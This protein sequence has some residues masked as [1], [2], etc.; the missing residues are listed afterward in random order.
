MK[1]LP[2]CITLSRI[3]SSLAL[4]FVRTFSPMFFVI[5]TYC[6]VSDVL[7]G[8]LA[9][10]FSLSSENGARLD[11]IADIVCYG[12]TAVKIMPSLLGVLTSPIWWLITVV[13]VIRI[14]SYTVAMIKYHCFASLH[15][16]MNKL[17]GFLIFTIPYIIAQPFAL[18][19]SIIITLVALLAASEEL[20]IHISANQYSSNRKTLFVNR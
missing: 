9:R 19:A 13:L 12:I 2:N 17:T 4:L 10:K 14:I 7:D 8:F 11:S 16:Y 5:Y 1:H 15:T 6:G 20:I 3:A 18:P